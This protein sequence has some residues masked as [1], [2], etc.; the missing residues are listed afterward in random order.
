MKTNLVKLIKPE[1]EW[2][3]HEQVEGT[4]IGTGG[5]N[6]SLLQKAGMTCD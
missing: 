5:L 2:S 6:P 3:S 1:T 4:L